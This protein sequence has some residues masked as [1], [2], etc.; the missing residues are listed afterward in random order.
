MNLWVLAMMTGIVGGC[1]GDR[2]GTGAVTLTWTPI[3]SVNATLPVAIRVY[4]GQNDV[5]PLRA[6]YVTIDE[7]H[8][9]VETRVLLSAD[10]G[11]LRETVTSFSKRPRSCVAVN[12]GYFVMNQAPSVHAGL[13]YSDGKL[14]APATRAVTRADVTYP[15]AR[16]AIG[17][18]ADGGVELAW[19]T[20]RDD[21]LFVWDRPPAHRP[22][23]PAALPE[24]AAVFWDVRDAVSAGPMLVHRGR[25]HVTDDEEV[26]FGS[27]IPDVHPRTAAGRTAD[28]RLLLLV[29][30]GRQPVSRGVDLEQLAGIMED[31]GA[32]EALNLDGGGSSALVVNGTLLNRPTGTSIEREVMSAIVT[33]CLPSSPEMRTP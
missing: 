32:V 12:G 29:V 30:D 31:I 7:R 24:R 1:I 5:Y 17:F 21:S 23:Q 11:D 28:G 10:A 22:G 9:L 26:F 6:W 19:A 15:V 4:A 3:D 16:A 25:Q 13:L 8:P 20:N 14:E 27:A 18:T 2:S 33:F